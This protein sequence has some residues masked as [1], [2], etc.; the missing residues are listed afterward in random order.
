LHEGSGD[1]LHK[2][3]HENARRSPGRVRARPFER[4]NP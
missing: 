2:R 3:I 4:S 1:F